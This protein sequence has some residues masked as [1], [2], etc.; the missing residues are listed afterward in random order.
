L[1]AEHF[2]AIVRQSRGAGIMAACG[3]LRHSP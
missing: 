2:T 1:Q 3:Q